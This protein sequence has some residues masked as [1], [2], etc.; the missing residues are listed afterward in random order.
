MTLRELLWLAEARARDNWAHTSTLLALLAN[1]HR[2]PKK[3]RPF[4]PADFDPYTPKGEEAI[5]ITD[6]GVL[7]GA[8]K[9]ERKPT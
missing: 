3:T 2:D 7:K 8:F 9:K 1:C 6:M 5:R 4:K